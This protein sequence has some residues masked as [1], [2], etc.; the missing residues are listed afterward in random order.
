MGFIAATIHFLLA[1]AAFLLSLTHK[2]TSTH[3]YIHALTIYLIDE[4]VV[5]RDRM[6]GVC[7]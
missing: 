3:E 4:K 7:A 5:Q 2:H 6:G 1:I